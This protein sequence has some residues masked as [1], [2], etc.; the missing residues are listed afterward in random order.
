MTIEKEVNGS[1]AKL[2]LN[3]WMDT[4]NAPQLAIAVDALNPEV[5]SLV[6]DMAGLEYM[7]SAGIR[8]LVATH[9]RMNGELTLKNVQPVIMDVLSTLGFDKKLKF[10]P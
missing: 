5:K 8:Q 4:E 1:C 3:G 10:E 6:L 2:I 9:K 7:S